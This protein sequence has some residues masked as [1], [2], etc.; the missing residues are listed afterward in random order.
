MMCRFFRDFA[1]TLP[2]ELSEDG[3][4][5]CELA[6]S[7]MCGS[8]AST[9][10]QRT[11]TQQDVLTCVPKFWRVEEHMS[12]QRLGLQRPRHEKQRDIW[13]KVGNMCCLHVAY[14]ANY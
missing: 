2:C 9:T 11:Y 3:S 8:G 14:L 7:Q 5:G 13:A 10:M 6:F 4:D 1:S 12:N